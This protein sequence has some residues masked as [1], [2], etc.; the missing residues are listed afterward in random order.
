VA[1]RAVAAL[2]LWVVF[3]GTTLPLP[4][5]GAPVQADQ[6]RLLGIVGRQ[7]GWLNLDAPR[8]Q[9]L[10]S[11]DSPA[12]V[13]DV[14]AVPTSPRAVVAVVQ[15]LGGEPGGAFGGDLLALDLNGQAGLSP[16]LMRVDGGEWLSAPAWLPD[17]SAVLFQREDVRA[18]PDLY[19]GQAEVRYPSRI[20]SVSVIGQGRDLLVESGFNPSPAPDGSEVAFVRVSP[21]GTSLLARDTASGQERT[22]VP[23]GAQPDLAY[24][25]YAPSGQQMAFLATTASLRAPDLLA[26]LGPQVAYA[27]GYPWDL[28]LV[29]RDGSG[30]RKLAAVGAD[31]G[32]LTWSPDGSEIFVYG[33]TGARL[34][35][36]PSGQTTLL[37]YLAGFGAIAWLPD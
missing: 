14:A 9:V 26:W 12:F 3:F 33:T 11:L 22:L 16:F 2:V 31:D 4:S 28:W 25:R 7:V 34:V 8:P 6:G 10:T 27:H 19:A 21:R 36:V 23:V 35:E 29:E 37:P 30:L 24:P 20:E 5:P 13:M 32:S 15:R 17:G 18:G 1:R